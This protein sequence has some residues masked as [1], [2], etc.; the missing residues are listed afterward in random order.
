MAT[1]PVFAR[2]QKKQRVS[3]L[4]GPL[5]LP[6]LAV[7]SERRGL[8]GLSAGRGRTRTRDVEVVLT[9]YGYGSKP[10]TP[11]EHPNPH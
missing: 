9:P 7:E 10:R 2:A 11:S 6:Q 4:R 1:A 5:A 3:P 8:R